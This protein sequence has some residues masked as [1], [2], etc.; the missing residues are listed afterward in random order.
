MSEKVE[1]TSTILVSDIVKTVFSF[2]IV[3]FFVIIMSLITVKELKGF[4]YGKVNTINISD[5][6]EEVEKTLGKPTNVDGDYY[7]YYSRSYRD[8]VNGVKKIFGDSYTDDMQLSD[9]KNLLDESSENYKQ[10]IDSLKTLKYDYICIKFDRREQVEWLVLDKEI[11]LIEEPD[12][13]I[14][15]QNLFTDVIKPDESIDL[16]YQISYKDGSLYKFVIE[17]N[18][19]PESKKFETDFI[20]N[21]IFLP[22]TFQGVDYWG[23]EFSKSIKLT[24][25]ED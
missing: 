22:K 21:K 23:K 9:V 3:A 10:Q 8:V 11:S 15:S 13:E 2:L 24:I 12:K 18:F 25:S 20:L 14:Y 5:T 7:E 4:S 16:I 1:K 17:K 19:T 6:K